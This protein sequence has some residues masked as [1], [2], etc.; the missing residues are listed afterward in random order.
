MKRIAVTGAAGRVGTLLRP[1]LRAHF[2][3]VRLIDLQ[4]PAELGE[5]ETFVRADLTK[6]DE[7][8]VALKDI[9]GVVHL[10]GI[11]SGID[12]NAILHANVL[13]TYNLYEAARINEVQRVVYASSNHATGFYPRGEVISPLDPMRPDSPYGLSKCWGELVAGLYYD[14]SGIRS[15]S[16]RIGNA[17]TYP[18]SERSVAIWISARDLAQL[19]RIGLTH[20]LIAATVVYGVSDTDEKWWDNDLARRLGYQ[21]EDRPRDHARIEQG[22]EGPVALAFQGG[23][24]CEINHDG[25]IRMRDAEG[26]AKSLEAAE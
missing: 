21:P 1:H 5:N 23:G 22:A 24:F 18:N 16:I 9:D 8:G 2:E 4:E 3:H 7:A 12:M 19:V 6:L 25:T 14:T 13:G 17:G 15:L 26:L 10:A 20:P 11:A